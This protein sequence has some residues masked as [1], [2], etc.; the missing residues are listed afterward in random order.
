MSVFAA[1]ENL[2]LNVQSPANEHSK[3]LLLTEDTTESWLIGG[4]GQTS[5]CYFLQADGLIG[6]GTTL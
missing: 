2:M 1:A 6:D 5:S 3:E 4:W